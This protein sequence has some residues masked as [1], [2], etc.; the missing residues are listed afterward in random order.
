MV[1]IHNR[2]ASSVASL[3]ITHHWL[4]RWLRISAE[5]KPYTSEVN[6]LKHYELLSR[7]QTEAH[8]R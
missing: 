8:A 1:K 7:F 5:K 6:G 2:N 4:A 3:M